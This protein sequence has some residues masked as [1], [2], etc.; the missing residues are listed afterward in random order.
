M[1]IDEAKGPAVDKDVTQQIDRRG[2][3]GGYHEDLQAAQGNTVVSLPSGSFPPGLTVDP[4]SAS[5]VLFTKSSLITN[6]M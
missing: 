5:S 4:W 2:G 3:H 6:M 1:G